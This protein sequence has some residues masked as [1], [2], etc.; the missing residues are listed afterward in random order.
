MELLPQEVR[1]H[2]PPLYSQ[3]HVEDPMVM[4]KFFTPDANWTWYVLEFNGE[5]LFF[6]LVYGFE[7]ELGYFSLAELEAARG[8]LGLSIERDI[9]FTP[10][11][12]SE[13]RKEHA[14]QHGDT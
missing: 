13:V 4:C 7:T 8:P 5:D 11:K 12:L 9:H 6:G 1:Q 14:E 2:L 10:K 3:E